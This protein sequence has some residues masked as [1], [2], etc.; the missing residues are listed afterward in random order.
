VP[1]FALTVQF[2]SV[3]V[4][5]LTPSAA[6]TGAVPVLWFVLS[7][8]RFNVSVD[9]AWSIAPLRSAEL[10]STV[11]SVS[12]TTPW[13]LMPPP[14]PSIAPLGFVATLP[15]MSPPVALKVDAT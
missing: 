6:A 8:T 5:A 9:P 3:A 10:P 7:V 15:T 14:M 13:L 2:V 12:D 11:T 4:P 1:R